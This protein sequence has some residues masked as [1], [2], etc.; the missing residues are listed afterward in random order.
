MSLMKNH[1]YTA[2]M[3]EIRMLA[4]NAT[5]NADSRLSGVGF[6]P[7]DTWLRH[8]KNTVERMATP[9]AADAWR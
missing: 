5:W 1:A 2:P 7:V 6:G 4:A 3:N 9:N 8:E